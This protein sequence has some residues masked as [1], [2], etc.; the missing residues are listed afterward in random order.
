MTGPDRDTTGR[1]FGAVFD[2]V[3]AVLDQLAVEGR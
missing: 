3:L 1:L 2:Q